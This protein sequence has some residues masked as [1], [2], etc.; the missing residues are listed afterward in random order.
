MKFLSPLRFTAQLLLI[1]FLAGCDDNIDANSPLADTEPSTTQ[2]VDVANAPPNTLE[3]ENATDEATQNTQ[4]II[5]STTLVAIGD[6]DVEGTIEFVQRGDTVKVTG[7][8]RGLSPGKHGFHVHEKGDLSDTETG[9]SAG[10]H[11][12]PTHQEHGKPGEEKRHVG[13]LGNIEANEDGVAKIDIT[14]EVISL[15]GP[16]SIIGRSVM[17]HEGEDQF[18]QPTGDAGGRVAF[19]KIEKN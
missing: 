10:G 16:N 13:D 9:K 19:G 17:I 6:N 11:F 5:A 18:T 7:E 3:N 12:N 4:P 1:V 2:N 15:D 8:V 14:D